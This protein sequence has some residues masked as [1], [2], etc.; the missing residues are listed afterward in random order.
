[1]NKSLFLLL[2]S[3]A[4]LGASTL[5][6]QRSTKAL[7]AENTTF[8]YYV[9]GVLLA[10]VFTGSKG[11]SIVTNPK[12]IVWTLFAAGTMLFSV[13]LF[14][15]ALKDTSTSLAATIRSLAFV[16]TIFYELIFSKTTLSLQTVAGSALAIAAIVTLS[17][18]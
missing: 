3:S 11:V 7:G 15:L 4:L 13:Y 17:K 14:N 1:M 12:E 8:W 10:I 16:F 6:F 2:A 9:F 18:S 5:F